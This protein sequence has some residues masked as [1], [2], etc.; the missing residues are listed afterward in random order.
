MSPPSA[1]NCWCVEPAA[2]RIGT[3]N[4]GRPVGSNVEPELPPVDVDIGKTLPAFFNR[5]YSVSSVSIR[6]GISSLTVS[7]ST[8]CTAASLRAAIGHSMVDLS[9]AVSPPESASFAAAVCGTIVSARRRLATFL[10]QGWS[11]RFTE[12]ADSLE[13]LGRQKLDYFLGTLK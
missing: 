4:D 12:T 7:S 6:S 13:D 1:E 3:R 2:M 8:A 9:F 10:F 5:A 11:F